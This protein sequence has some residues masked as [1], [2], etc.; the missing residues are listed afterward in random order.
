MING[1]NFRLINSEIIF[2]R[3]MCYMKRADLYRVNYIFRI[4]FNKNKILIFLEMLR[5]F[6]SS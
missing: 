4:K 2:K 3:R 6:K 5:D 1:R